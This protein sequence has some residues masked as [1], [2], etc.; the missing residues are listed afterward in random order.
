[1]HARTPIFSDSRSTRLIS[2]S[3][4]A[5]KQAIY[6][7]RRVLYMHEGIDDGEYAFYQVDGKMN[8]ADGGT[9]YIGILEFV[10]ARTYM[11]VIVVSKTIMVA[12][13]RLD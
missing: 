4:S 12:K 10:R 1:M 7:A 11:G 2:I 3:A 8:P 13:T 9:K 5:M 6:L